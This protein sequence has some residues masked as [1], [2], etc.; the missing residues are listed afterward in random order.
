MNLDV[1]FSTD[2]ETLAA[3]F[4]ADCQAYRSASYLYSEICAKS[5][6]SREEAVRL[7]QQRWDAHKAKIEAAEN[8]LMV[9][10]NEKASALR[11]AGIYDFHSNLCAGAEN[12]TILF[13]VADETVKLDEQ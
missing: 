9:I 5:E 1:V 2:M 8:V 11:D 10:M 6:A 4:S 13:K 3:Q 7:R 12:A